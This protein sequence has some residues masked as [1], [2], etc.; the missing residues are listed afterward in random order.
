M[1]VLVIVPPLVLLFQSMF[2]E[3]FG[4]LWTFFGIPMMGV[5]ATQVTVRSLIGLLGQLCF[6]GFLLNRLNVNLKA[7]AVQRTISD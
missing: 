7:L 5:A 3:D 4:I 1:A 2:P 6:L